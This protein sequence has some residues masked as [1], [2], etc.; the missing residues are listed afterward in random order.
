MANLEILM[1]THNRLEYLQKALP[2]V[3][4]QT[5][6]DWHLT[7]WDNA[8]D[9]PTTE[10]LKAIEDKRVKVVFAGSNQSLAQVTTK[11]FF[12]SDTKFV[13]KID[14]DMIITPDWAKRLIDKHQEGHFGFIG[15]FH[16]RPEDLNRIE[17]IIENGVWRK[18]H[19]GGQFIIRREDFGGYQGSGV[20]GLSE[21]QAEM[22]YPNGYLWDPILWVDHMEDPRSEHFINTPE[23]NEY[24]LKARGMSIDQYSAG[25]IN[26]AYMKEN[27]KL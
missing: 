5:Y 20:M 18:H 13:G 21:Y 2:S 23:Y 10:W 11:V 16:F 27:T 19:I 24:K 7:I 14:P 15:G 22:G 12:N 26:P 1:I 3:L 6:S 4:N 17:P 9:L 8:S 25:I